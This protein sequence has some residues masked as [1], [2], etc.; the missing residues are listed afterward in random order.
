MRSVG[1]FLLI[2]GL[3][4]A[5]LKLFFPGILLAVLM[6]V[7]NWGDTVGWSIRI[8][9]VVVGGLLMLVSMKMPRRPQSPQP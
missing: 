9:L 5:A 3:I 1:S 2:C 4:S 6:W 7:D 8:G